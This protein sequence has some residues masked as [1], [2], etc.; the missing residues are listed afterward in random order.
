MLADEVGPTHFGRAYGFERAADMLGA[1]AGP[2]I[3]FFLLWSGVEVK[4][5]ILASIL[6]SLVAV[7]AF[8]A[9]YVALLKARCRLAVAEDA[10]RT[11][12]IGD[13][14]ARRRAAAGIPTLTEVGT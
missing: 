10:V 9:L 2:L 13:A 4:T 1:V 7:V 11:D 8:T 6:P 14:V 5:I 12:A 3:A